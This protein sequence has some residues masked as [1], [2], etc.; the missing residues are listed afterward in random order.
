MVDRIKSAQSTMPPFR[1]LPDV[2]E[3]A[4]PQLQIDVLIE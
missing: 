1:I 3:Y 4:Q 2:G